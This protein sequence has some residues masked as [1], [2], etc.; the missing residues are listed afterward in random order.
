MSAALVK[1]CSLR[2]NLICHFLL[3]CVVVF[4]II[5]FV[6]G[7]GIAAVSRNI[8]VRLYVRLSLSTAKLVERF[9]MG[10]N[11]KPFKIFAS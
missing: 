1:N 5:H 8:A 11:G 9:Q 2:Q 10:L 3:C 4:A 6:V 7:G